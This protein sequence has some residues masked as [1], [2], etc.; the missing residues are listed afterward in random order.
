LL[1]AGWEARRRECEKDQSDEGLGK[2][3]LSHEGIIAQ[4]NRPSRFAV[5]PDL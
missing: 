1:G 2:D 5:Q 3:E 4:L